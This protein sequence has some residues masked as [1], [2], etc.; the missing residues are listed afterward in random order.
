MSFTY[1]ELPGDSQLG[2]YQT[3]SGNSFSVESFWY[4]PYSTYLNYTI[5]NANWSAYFTI[6]SATIRKQLWDVSIAP[7]YF[8]DNFGT[9]RPGGA[10]GT[11]RLLLS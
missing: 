3:Q 4:A 10:I 9:C 6:S 7:W 1:S 11:Q 8:D 2:W 5:G